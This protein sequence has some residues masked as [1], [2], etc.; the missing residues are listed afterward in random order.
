[1]IHLDLKI[2]ERPSPIS[3][4]LLELVPS[5][6]LHLNSFEYSWS[7]EEFPNKF[8]EIFEIEFEN[9]EKFLRSQSNNLNEL[10]LKMHMSI[11]N[12]MERQRNALEPPHQHNINFNLKLPVLQK[13]RKFH[14]CVGYHYDGYFIDYYYKYDQLIY[15]NLCQICK[16]FI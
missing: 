9:L 11:R 13:L 10:K 7:S 14:L 5:G 2:H 1:M 4:E 8:R 16:K 3:H 6:D 12:E 15:Q